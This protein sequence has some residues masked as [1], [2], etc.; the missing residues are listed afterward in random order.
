MPLFVYGHTDDDVKLGLQ[1]RA[2][3]AAAAAPT[4]TGDA[5]DDAAVVVDL[6]NGI[7]VQVGDVEV[8]IL[9]LGETV[10]PG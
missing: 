1:R 10:R 6:A 3:I 5:G 9:V 4:R 7:V 8:A 2:A